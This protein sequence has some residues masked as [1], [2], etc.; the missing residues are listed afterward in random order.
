MVI[1]YNKSETE[2]KLSPDDDVILALS[3]RWRL[4]LASLKLQRKT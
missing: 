2:K 1:F 3:T 4:M